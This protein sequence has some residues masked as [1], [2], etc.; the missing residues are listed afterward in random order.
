MAGSLIHVAYLIECLR[1]SNPS[2]APH[3]PA[4][5]GLVGP[6][7]PSLFLSAR[8]VSE[9]VAPHPS[10]QYHGHFHPVLHRSDFAGKQLITSLPP[11][12]GLWGLGERALRPKLVAR[13]PAHRNFYIFL[14]P[15]QY[16]D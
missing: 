1:V 10:G 2:P 6:S 4:G 16:F 7:P 11:K 14:I 15:Q 13:G 5:G 8:N 9:C 12:T 3:P